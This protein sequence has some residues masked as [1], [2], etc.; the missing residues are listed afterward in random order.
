MN[1]RTLLV[2]LA[3]A[4]AVLSVHPFPSAAQAGGSASHPSEAPKAAPWK[5]AV[6]GDSRNCGDVVMP[7]IAAGVKKKR[8]RFYWHLGDFRQISRLRR[9]H[10]APARAY[11]AKPLT[12]AEYHDIAW[13]DFIRNQIVPFGAL[14]V[15]LGIGNHETVRPRPARSISFQF[16]TLART[17]VLRAQRLRD[18]PADLRAEDLLPLD[19]ARRGFHQSRQRHRGP[20]RRGPGC[21]VRKNAA[22]DSANAAIRTIV[23]GMHEALPESISKNHSMNQSEAGIESGRRVYA[24]LLESAERSAQARLRPRQPFALFHGR[25][26]QHRVLARARRRAARMDRRDGRRRALRPAPK[27][28]GCK[29]GRRPMSTDFCSPR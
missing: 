16:A 23:V 4:L 6:S 19:R 24:D 29:G 28:G 20:V 11:V 26:F 8:R 3:L 13:N 18:D 21:L 1:G 9:R 10:P 2:R 27:E 17:P 15:Y 12:I 25:H 5:F 7:A 22:L 14:P